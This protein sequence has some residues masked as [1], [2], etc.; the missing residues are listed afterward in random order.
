MQVRPLRRQFRDGG[1][2]DGGSITAAAG[3]VTV[4]RPEGE[5]RS[6]HLAG[7]T[8]AHPVE[9][10]GIKGL[11]HLLRAELRR[12]GEAAEP[13]RATL[14]AE[15]GKHPAVRGVAE[16]GHHQVE[17]NQVKPVLPGKRH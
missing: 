7:V 14:L 2:Q 9:L 8:G 17:E 10:A 13:D 4:R 11:P 15:H 5:R 3:R 16:P 6:G 1:L 12:V